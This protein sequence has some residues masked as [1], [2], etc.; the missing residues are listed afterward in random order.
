[1][2]K[3]TKELNSKTINELEKMEAAMYE[4]LAKIRLQEKV[5]PSKDKN[6]LFKKRKQLAV[7]LTVKTQKKDLEELKKTK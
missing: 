6:L 7:I 4:E 2:K 3:Y 1:M 5:N